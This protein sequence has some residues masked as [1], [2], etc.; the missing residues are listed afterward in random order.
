MSLPSDIS[1]GWSLD[2]IKQELQGRQVFDDSR[3]FECLHIDRVSSEFVHNC[4]TGFDK[5][6]RIAAVRSNVEKIVSI[7]RETYREADEI[8]D[9][10]WIAQNQAEIKQMYQPLMV[11]F[12][13]IQNFDNSE[14]LNSPFRNSFQ[15]ADKIETESEGTMLGFPKAMPAFTMLDFSSPILTSS[16]RSKYAVR[17]H[18]QA[19]FC[20]IMASEQHSPNIGEVKPIVAQAA[21]YARLHLSAHPFQLFSVGL[22]IFGLKFCVA[23]FDRGGVCFSPICSIFS[24]V[25]TF[26]RVIHAMEFHLSPVELGRDPTVTALSGQK[27]QEWLDYVEE[28]LN[29]A[30]DRKDSYPT[31]RVKGIPGFSNCK[32]FTIGKPIWSSLSLLGRGTSIWMVADKNTGEMFVLKNA[33]RQD[34]RNS[35]SQIY[36]A[37]TGKHP[38]L[39]VFECS[40]DVMFRHSGS[41]R[42]VS[43]QN[44]RQEGGSKNPNDTVN[45]IIFH[46]LLIRTIGRSILQWT[47]YKELL[48]GIRDAIS[49]YEFLCNQGILH[50]DIKQGMNGAKGFLMD[51]EFAHIQSETLPDNVLM[52]DVPPMWGAFGFLTEAMRGG[53]MTGTAH[54]MAKEVL[55][56]IVHKND[57]FVHQVHHDV[58]SFIY[59]LAYALFGALVLLPSKPRIQELTSKQRQSLKQEFYGSFGRMTLR[60]ILWD[61]ESAHII[62]MYM[63]PEL[64]D[65]F[66]SA[67]SYLFN[68]LGYHLLGQVMTTMGPP[69]ISGGVV[70]GP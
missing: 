9:E 57:K 62:R 68:A 13:Y 32:L 58:E 28:N 2:S 12:E 39:A 7:A 69:V 20:E 21:N 11:L 14:S 63:T 48:L 10:E 61:R 16:L 18:H 46:H 55:H 47:T 22:L 24:D 15:S 51:V 33:W 60:N 3:I 50:R 5:D 38:T 1:H 52:E 53:V 65:Y 59:V 67:L 25:E 54:F 64:K 41:S 26:I 8:D 35:E 34:N 6:A 70:Q 17:W 43:V 44:L 29:Y 40:G 19:A 45:D 30:I 4:K 42:N 56:A 49:A 31:F 23:I 66:P 37:I 27:Q 36:E